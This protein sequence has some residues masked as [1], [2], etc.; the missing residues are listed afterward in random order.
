VRRLAIVIAALAFGGC[1]AG[2][3]ADDPPAK[4]DAV[5]LPEDFIDEDTDFFDEETGEPEDTE[6]PAEDT[7]VPGM[8]TAPKPDGGCTPVCTT[9]GGANGCGGTCMTGSCSAGTCVAGK[10]VTPTRSY[11]SP[12]DYAFGTAWARGIT[13][14]IGSEDTATIRYT[15]DGSTPSA[16]S[17][18]KASPADLFISTSG[19][20][21]KW[22]ADNGAK[23]GVQSFTANI[24]AS[25]QS[26][27][28]YIVEK[29]NLGGKGPT[30]VTSAGATITG[31]ATYQA[32]NSTGCPGCRYQLVYGIETTSVGCL[33]DYS[34]GAWP[35]ASGSGSISL[36]APTVPG[37][38]DINVSYTLELSCAN[39]MAANP[40]NSRPTARIGTIVVR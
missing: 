35:G 18:S 9:C 4:R 7:D 2:G 30:I 1:V 13:Y 17:A 39:G 40:I 6:A 22:Y 15:L 25:G 10:C 26:A 5:G 36:K 34:P 28:G 29:T 16:T 27:Y 12:G 11:L 21:I 31:S 19:T 14:T 33:Y 38:Y 23:E 3:A 32:W 37:V 24:L 8:D 20:V